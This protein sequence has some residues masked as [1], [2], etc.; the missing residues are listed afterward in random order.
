[1]SIRRINSTGRKKILR[2]DVR[3][4]VHSDSD[5][6]LSFD[7]TLNLAD[8]GLPDSANVFVEAY[9]PMSFMRF[10]FGTVTAPQPPHG[11]SR[12]LTEFANSAGLLWRVKVTSAEGRAGVLLAKADRIPASDDEE[13]PDNRMALLPAAP[14]ELGQEIWR[15]DLDGSG[16]PQLLVNNRVGDWKAVAASPAFRSLVYP[17]AMRQV[18]WHIYKVEEMRTMDDLDDWRCLWLSFAA[19]LPSVGDPPLDSEDDDV[20]KDW[21]TEAAESFTRQHQMLDRYKAFLAV[22][23]GT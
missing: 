13:Q 11:L 15:L 17:A 18:L 12:R 23:T 2:K 8:Y 9:R 16:G 7:A 4:F 14:A 1:M 19:R 3:I 20:W 22:E 6:D 21:I 5:G 10:P